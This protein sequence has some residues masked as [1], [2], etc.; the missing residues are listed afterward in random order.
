[1]ANL[2]KETVSALAENGKTI[3]DIVAVQGDDFGISIDEFIQL[4][5]ETNYRKCY[6]T[7]EVAEDLIIIGKDWWLERVEYNGSEWWKFR[8]FPQ[9]KS[10]IKSVSQLANGSYSSLKQLN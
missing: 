4:A 6:G 9:I 1:M 3:S 5:S 7:Q 10:N 8:Q 2:L